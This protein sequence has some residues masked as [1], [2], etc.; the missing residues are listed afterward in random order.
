MSYPIERAAACPV[1]GARAG[2]GCYGNGP[3]APGS[4]RERLL[5]AYREEIDRLRSQIEELSSGEVATE[6]TDEENRGN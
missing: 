3:M 5:K 2:H 1:C 4:H 6:A